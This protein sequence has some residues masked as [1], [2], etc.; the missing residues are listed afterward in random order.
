MKF[1]NNTAINDDCPMELDE[2]TLLSYTNYYQHSNSHLDFHNNLKNNIFGYS[3]A[4]CETLVE[5]RFLKNF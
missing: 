1:L 4:V 2:V 5:K 3:C